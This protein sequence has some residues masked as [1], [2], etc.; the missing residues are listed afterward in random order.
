M[1]NTVTEKVDY[2]NIAYARIQWT[3]RHLTNF[4][5]RIAL[6]LLEQ[7]SVRGLKNSEA[8]ANYLRSGPAMYGWWCYPM[9]M[10]HKLFTSALVPQGSVSNVAA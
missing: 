8:Q 7:L 10:L 5:L 6:L 3:R 2:L 9:T 1:Q 4:R